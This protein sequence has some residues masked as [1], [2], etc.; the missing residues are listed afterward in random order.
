MSNDIPE[1]YDPT[2][3]VIADY[4]QIEKVPIMEYD[5]IND[6]IIFKNKINPEIGITASST[7]NLSFASPVVFD[8]SISVGFSDPTQ[9]IPTPLPTDPLNLN[10]PSIA[11]LGTIQTTDL[12]VA[13]NGVMQLYA[14]FTGTHMYGNLTVDGNII[15]SNLTDQI[16]NISLTPGPQ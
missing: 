16:N 1:D 5:Q 10:I 2:A 15:N 7:N 14:D 8:S 11:S 6:S 12:M 4:S 9:F 3:G 13:K